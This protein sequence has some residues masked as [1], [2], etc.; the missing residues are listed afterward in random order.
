MQWCKTFLTTWQLCRMWIKGWHDY[1]PNLIRERNFTDVSQLKNAKNC[2]VVPKIEETQPLVF[3]QMGGAPQQWKSAAWEFLYPKLAGRFTG[4][5]APNPQL[6]PPLTLPF[7]FLFWSYV[8][9]KCTWVAHQHDQ[10]WDTRHIGVYGAEMR[11]YLMWWALH[12]RQH[13]SSLSINFI[14]E[15]KKSARPSHFIFSDLLSEHVL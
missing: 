1:W 12:G 4:R 5:G 8:M 7:E 6:L 3:L 11:N 15:G 14:P 13:R 10:H 9:D 2:C